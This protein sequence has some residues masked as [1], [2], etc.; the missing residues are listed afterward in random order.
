MRYTVTIQADANGNMTYMPALLRANPGDTVEWRCA[1]GDFALSFN[2]RSPFQRAYF[3]GLGNNEPTPQQQ[4][5]TDAS[6]SYHY[7][8][9]VRRND[10]K[11]WSDSGSPEIFI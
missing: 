11:I 7:D 1:D 10:G 8:V 9:V 3:Q 4:I 2:T 6:G 5:A